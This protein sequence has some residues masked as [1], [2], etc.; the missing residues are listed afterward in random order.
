MPQAKRIAVTGAAGQIAYNLLPRI[1]AGEIYGP[2]VPVILQL[3]EIPAAIGTL[4]GVRMELLDCAFPLVEGIICSDDPEVAFEGADLALLVGSKPRGPGMERNDLIKENGPIF[5]GQ[6]KALDK[7]ASKDVRVVVVGNPCNTNCL[8][9]M[10]NAPSIPKKNFSAMTQ[11]D[12]NRAIAQIV[13]RSGV[14]T[15]DVENVV[16]WGNHS[17]TQ[18]PDWSNAHV[19]GI[20]AEEAIKDRDWFIKHLIPTVQERGKEIIKARG[21]SSAA[22]AASAAIDHCRFLFQGTR[23]YSWT[24][25]AVCSDGSYGADEGLIFSFPVRCKGNGDYLI[26]QDLSFDDFGKEKF[27]ITLE[28]LRREKATIA[29]LLG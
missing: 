25:M 4:D 9:A 19:H 2:D 29:D 6:G 1:A 5:V 15:Q 28:E 11:L 18:F 27:E 21:K 17:N 20:S 26:V 23:G 3:L 10:H 14:P 16:I 12:H 8:I 7:V 24:S 13:E 22:S